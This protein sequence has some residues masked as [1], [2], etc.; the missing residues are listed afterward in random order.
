MRFPKSFTRTKGS[1]TLLLGADTFP[2][3]GDGTFRKPSANDTNCFFTKAVSTNGWPLSRII[4]HAVY[5]GSATVPAALPI[6]VYVFEE[7]ENFWFLL[8]QSATTLVPSTPSSVPAT[9]TLP[10]Y[11][12]TV[13]LI[14][15]PQRFTD[16][17]AATSGAAAYLV[18]VGDPGAGAPAGSYTFIVGGELSPKA[19]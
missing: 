10:V 16:D 8:P 14:D 18:I 11:F 5:T 17:G 9:A 15:L 4:V 12:N 13:S 19:F 6:A 3:N 1:G 7:H 2:T